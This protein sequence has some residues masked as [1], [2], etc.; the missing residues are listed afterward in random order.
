MN[1]RTAALPVALLAVAL[2]A[3][4]ATVLAILSGDSWAGAL[5]GVALLCTANSAGMFVRH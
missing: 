5:A 4:M 2:I 3:T 1:A